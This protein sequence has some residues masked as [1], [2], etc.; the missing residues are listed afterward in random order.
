MKNILLDPTD[1]FLP[2]YLKAVNYIEDIL[3]LL[4]N[5][6]QEIERFYKNIPS[7]K[8]N[9]AYADGKWTVSEVLQHII[10]CERIIAMRALCFAR[11]EKQNLPS[12]DQDLYMLNAQSN[13]SFE[14]KIEEFLTLRK[15]HIYMFNSFSEA[16]LQKT[17]TSSGFN[18]NV[19]AHIYIIVGHEIH[20][21]NVLENFYGTIIGVNNS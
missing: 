17:G 2:N 13:N 3:P 10:D 8:H 16:Q 6:Y 18:R 1:I 11:G 15:S 21:R 9:F 19:L 12:F 14:D 7:E 20:H 4:N 5:S